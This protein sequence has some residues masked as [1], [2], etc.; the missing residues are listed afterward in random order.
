[1]WSLFM[2]QFSLFCLLVL[3]KPIQIHLAHLGLGTQSL[4]LNQVV[5]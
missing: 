2:G 4:A 1:M 3:E 5:V